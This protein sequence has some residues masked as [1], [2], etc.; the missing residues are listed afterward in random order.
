MIKVL[1]SKIETEPTPQCCADA[2]H[3]WCGQ[4]NKRM[5]SFYAERGW[6]SSKCRR[7]SAYEID[8]EPFCTQHARMV[9]LNKLI[10][11]EG[12]VS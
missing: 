4:N 5:E 8:G 2:G 3:D 6:D 7:F 11:R 10:Q 1:V 9:A 12:I